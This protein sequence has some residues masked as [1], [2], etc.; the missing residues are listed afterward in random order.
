MAHRVFDRK[1]GAAFINSLPTGPGVYLFRDAARRVLYVGKAKNLRRR[2]QSYR[3]AGRRKVH[4]KMRRLIREAASVEVGARDT[5]REAL[6][7]ENALILELTPPFNVDGAYTFLYPAIGIGQADAH[8]LLGF[9]T[10]PQAW[11]ALDL[12]WFGAFRSRLR[13]KAAFDG[14]VELLA[15]IG[16]PSPRAGLPAH[17]RRR[18]ARLVGL[19]RLPGE[20]TAGLVPFLGGEDRSFLRTLSMILLTRARALRDAALVEER[21]HLLDEFF[22]VDASRL[23]LAMARVGRRGTFVPANERDALFIAARFDGV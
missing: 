1:F 23:R 3:H 5:E 18:G 10:T 15:L 11:A 9:T 19:R 6:L 20:L 13:A 21:L 22:E 16:H 7:E 2:L 4:R 14:L 17:A 8:T 12:R